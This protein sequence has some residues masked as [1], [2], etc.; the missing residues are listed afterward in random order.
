MAQEFSKLLKLLDIN[1]RR[2]FY[3][4]RHT[5]ETQAGESRDQIAVD[6]LMGHSDNSMAANYRHDISDARLRDVVAVVH[7]WLWPDTA[8]AGD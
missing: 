4:F 7:R 1:G 2:G 6:H 5:F 8:N 3:G